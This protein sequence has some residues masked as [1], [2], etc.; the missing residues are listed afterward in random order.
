MANSTPRMCRACH[1]STL[2][3]FSRPQTSE[4]STSY[5]QQ[6]YWLSARTLKNN[7]RNPGVF[8]IR[9][10]MYVQLPAVHPHSPS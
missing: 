3:N 2:E 8:Y 10:V 9:M 5:L 7:A 1:H 4:Y 6:F